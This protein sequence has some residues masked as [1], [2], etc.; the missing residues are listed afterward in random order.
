MARLLAVA[1]PSGLPLDVPLSTQPNWHGLQVPRG[2]ALHTLPQQSAAWLLLSFTTL[3]R[4]MPMARVGWCHSPTVRLCA[5]LSATLTTPLRFSVILLHILKG[6][7]VIAVSVSAQQPAT[8]VYLPLA[9]RLCS[10]TT[11]TM[12]EPMTRG[13]HGLR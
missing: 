7:C 6:Q 4:G 8:C 13:R 9:L 5:L 12:T 10:S 1:L 2:L 3:L 11:L